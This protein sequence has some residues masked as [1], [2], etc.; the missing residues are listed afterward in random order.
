AR[1]GDGWTER[2]AAASRSTARWWRR[3]RC[4]ER[5]WRRL[6]CPTSPLCYSPRS[7][8]PATT[9]RT[10]PA[11]PARRA[12]A[13]RAQRR[14]PPLPRDQVG[15]EVRCSGPTSAAR[16]GLQEHE[17]VLSLAGVEPQQRRVRVIRLRRR[18]ILLGDMEARDP[19]RAPLPHPDPEGAALL[20]RRVDDVVGGV[21][22]DHEHPLGA[23]GGGERDVHRFLQRLVLEVLLVLSGTIRARLGGD[24]PGR[25]ARLEVDECTPLAERRSVLC[26]QGEIDPHGVIL[27]PA[28]QPAAPRP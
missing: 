23:L 17:R 25:P 12:G 3:S 1:Y 10:T 8:P 14:P 9:R 28:P 5:G 20:G 24:R 18:R 27:S 6:S 21:R 11:A 7:A 26:E 22:G 15:L 2:R 16:T 4:W 19:R 13:G